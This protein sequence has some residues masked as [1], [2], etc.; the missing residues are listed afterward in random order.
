M[1]L[2]IAVAL[3]SSLILIVF[4]SFPQAPDPKPLTLPLEC[5]GGDCDLLRGAPQTGGMRSGFVRLK[6]G[7][8][9]GW[10]TTGQHEEALVV[11]HGTG[12]AQI[13][14]R[15]SLPVASEMLVYIPPATRHNVKNTGDTILEYVYVVAPIATK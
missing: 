6:P 1:K 14:G 4:S 2:K 5:A 8:A 11:L 9:V 13:E 10:H 7:E 3:C 12:E 15:A